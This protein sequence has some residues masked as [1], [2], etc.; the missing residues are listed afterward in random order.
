MLPYGTTGTPVSVSGQAVEGEW[1]ALQ[2]TTGK[3][4]SAKSNNLNLIY[5]ASTS[6]LTV[7]SVIIN[8]QSISNNITICK[9]GTL[10]LKATNSYPAGTILNGCPVETWRA[11]SLYVVRSG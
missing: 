10:E 6:S 9:N 4:S 5:N 1:F 3:C 11:A 2:T 7:P 8:G